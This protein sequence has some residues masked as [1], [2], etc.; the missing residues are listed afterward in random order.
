MKKNEL[1]KEIFVLFVYVVY[2][3]Y[4]KMNNNLAMS[5]AINLLHLKK[6]KIR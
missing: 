1:M 6:K 5:K 4:V 2:F 3:F